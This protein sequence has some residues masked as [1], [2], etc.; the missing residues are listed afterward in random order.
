MIGVLEWYEVKGNN[1][2]MHESKKK[3]GCFK[4]ASY[5]MQAYVGATYF[6]RKSIA[7]SL[8]ESHVKFYPIP[9]GSLILCV[10]DVF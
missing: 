8:T 2:E 1:K 9:S 4:D 10:V 7:L 6:H 5:N 3:P